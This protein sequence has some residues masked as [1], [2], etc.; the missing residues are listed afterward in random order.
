MRTAERPTSG[1][2]LCRRRTL[3]DTQDY[4]AEL[5]ES[6]WL[7]CGMYMVNIG[8]SWCSSFL[9]IDGLCKCQHFRIRQEEMRRYNIQI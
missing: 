4:V 7:Q 1:P 9:C 2:G 8:S 6:A 3:S 5:L